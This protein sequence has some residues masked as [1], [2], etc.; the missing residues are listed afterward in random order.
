[1]EKTTH[2]YEMNI[3]KGKTGVKEEANNTSERMQKQEHFTLT[4][5]KRSAI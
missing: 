1:L 4:P 3:Y 2:K 5:L